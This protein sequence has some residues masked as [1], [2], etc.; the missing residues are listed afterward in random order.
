MDPW[1]SIGGYW[2]YPGGPMEGWGAPGASIWRLLGGLGPPLGPLG[3]LLV[4]L[5]GPRGDFRPFWRV[6]LG[7]LELILREILE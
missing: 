6:L 3:H 5:G 2:W 1:G 4:I 7:T